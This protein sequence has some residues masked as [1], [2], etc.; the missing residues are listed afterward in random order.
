MAAP[1]RALRSSS[2]RFC[3]PLPRR[4]GPSSTEPRQ[5]VR[6]APSAYTKLEP[7]V[8]QACQSTSRRGTVAA[9]PQVSVSLCLLAAAASATAAG[10]H[11]A[12]HASRPVFPPKCPQHD[13]LSSLAR[14]GGRADQPWLCDSRLVRFVDASAALPVTRLLNSSHLTSTQHMK[15][16]CTPLPLQGLMRAACASCIYIRVTLY[17][18]MTSGLMQLIADSLGLVCSSPQARQSSSLGFVGAVARS[19]ASGARTLASR[20]CT[21]ARDQGTLWSL[22]TATAPKQTARLSGV[23]H[24]HTRT[25]QR[26]AQRET[27]RVICPKDRVKVAVVQL[28]AIGLRRYR[29]GQIARY[30]TLQCPPGVPQVLSP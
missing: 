21:A 16:H 18:V 22:D 2:R 1:V 24:T 11:F 7:T 30:G 17:I 9:I 20:S 29:F 3:W 25:A 5:E 27:H 8:L 23:E 19:P 26:R 28:H 4:S 13:S 6:V 10:F 14:P 12:A 15:L